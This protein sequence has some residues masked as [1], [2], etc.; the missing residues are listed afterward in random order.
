[1]KPTILG[2]LREA[3]D[4]QRSEALKLAC[5]RARV[6][7][8]CVCVTEQAQAV[9][10]LSGTGDFADRKL[11]PPPRL[12]L[13]DLELP[14]GMGF[15]LLKWIRSQPAH[16]DLPVVVLGSLKHESDMRKAYGLGA[17]SYLIKP[18]SPEAFVEMLQ[19]LQLLWGSV[20]PAPRSQAA[21]HPGRDSGSLS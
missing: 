3:A 20:R 13:L 2:F 14:H 18:A 1:M 7:F 11:H 17:N 8:Q 16:E 12:V 5:A 6:P 9:A 15:A 4:P 19:T 10:Y 21:P